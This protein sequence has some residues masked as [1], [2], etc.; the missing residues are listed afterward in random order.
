[1]ALTMQTGEKRPGRGKQ[2]REYDWVPGLGEVEFLL[3]HGDDVVYSPGCDGFFH[4]GDVP[5]CVGSR[6]RYGF[7]S[8][9]GGGEAADMVFH[10]VDA[11]DFASGEGELAGE[12]EG[13]GEATVAEEDVRWVGVFLFVMEFHFGYHE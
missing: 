8:C 6:G 7:A 1:M 10:G 12:I 4:A 9:D 3:V 2:F 13:Y 11:V 5:R